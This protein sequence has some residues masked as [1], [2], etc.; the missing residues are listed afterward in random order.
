MAGELELEVK[1]TRGLR[2]DRRQRLEL[3]SGQTTHKH[4][5]HRVDGRFPEGAKNFV[6]FPRNANRQQR[7]CIV[8]GLGGQQVESRRVLMLF[9][10][11]SFLRLS[12]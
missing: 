9:F 5:C 2:S 11:T 1:S 12:F 4:Y 8:V 7:P 10:L 3:R 6:R